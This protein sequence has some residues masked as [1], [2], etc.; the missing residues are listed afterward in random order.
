[1]LG[2]MQGDALGVIQYLGPLMKHL[3][4]EEMTK[5]L[6]DFFQKLSGEGGEAWWMAFKRFLRKENPW[7]L[8]LDGGSQLE[9]WSLIYKEVFGLEIN[10]TSIKIPAQRLGF[11]CLLVIPKGLT[12]GQIV[13]VL[14]QKFDVSLYVEDL[15]QDV[16]VNYRV[17]TETYAIWIRDVVEADEDNKN[18]S[19]NQLKKQGIEG[20]TLMERLLYE[21]IYFTETGK[22]L[23]VENWTLCS[24]SLNSGGGVP[25]V[26]WDADRRGLRVG[27]F[28]PDRRSDRLRARAVVS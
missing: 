27:W 14:R 24:G 23:D 13:T 12:L 18:L 4:G 22:H 17:N 21:L 19:A 1:M 8:L 9:R 26:Y 7:I 11:E 6:L 16:T 5:T 10:V 15:N 25:G 3:I 28:D 2:T 20:V